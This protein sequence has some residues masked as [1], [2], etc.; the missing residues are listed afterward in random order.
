MEGVLPC[1]LCVRTEA[2]WLCHTVADKVC[3]NQCIS[4]DVI[5]V[6]WLLRRS[7]CPYKNLAKTASGGLKICGPSWHPG[8]SPGAAT[9][10]SDKQIKSF[11]PPRERSGGLKCARCAAMIAR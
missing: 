3:L 8:S 5:D 10:Y 9:I 6:S 4:F 2:V 1:P 7:A 11:R